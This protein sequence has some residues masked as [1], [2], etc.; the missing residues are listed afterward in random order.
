MRYFNEFVVVQQFAPFY[1]MVPKFTVLMPETVELSKLASTI[2]T[3]V[4]SREK[5]ILDLI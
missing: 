2:K 5:V 4:V 1:S 3:L